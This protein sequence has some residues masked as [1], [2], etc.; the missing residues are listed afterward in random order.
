M[1]TDKFVGKLAFLRIYS[2]Q[3]KKGQNIYNPRTRKR[4]RVSRLL[5]LHANHRED[6]DVLYAGEIGGMAGQKLFTTG[7][8]VCPENDTILLENIEFPEPVISMAI[9]P[10]TTADKDNLVDA[11]NDL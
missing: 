10:K 1:V 2:G 5:R 4:E 7:D 11:L 8:T 9:E 6:V 3:L